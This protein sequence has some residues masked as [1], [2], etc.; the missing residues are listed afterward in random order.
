MLRP[1]AATTCTCTF[2]ILYLFDQ[3]NLI[4]DGVKVREI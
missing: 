1:E 4:F 2:G 3:R